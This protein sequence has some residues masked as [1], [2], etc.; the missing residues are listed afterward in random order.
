MV[1]CGGTRATAYLLGCWAEFAKCPANSLFSTQ[2]QVAGQCPLCGSFL[3]L[4][5][6]VQIPPSPLLDGW[7]WRD[8]HTFW[9]SVSSS[10]N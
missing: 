6:L 1:G 10:V 9:A 7:P 2:P 5:E 8:A 4:V 3:G